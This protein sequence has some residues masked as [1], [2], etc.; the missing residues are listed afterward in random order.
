MSIWSNLTGTYR[1]H[2]SKAPSFKKLCKHYFEG[3]V[4]TLAHQTLLALFQRCLK[5]FLQ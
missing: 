4:I 1:I 2:Q 5:W 3:G